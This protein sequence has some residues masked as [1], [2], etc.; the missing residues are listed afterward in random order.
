MNEPAK[1]PLPKPLRVVI[2]AGTAIFLSPLFTLLPF[3]QPL[4]SRIMGGWALVWVA[5]VLGSAFVMLREYFSAPR[6]P[7]G[8]RSAKDSSDDYHE[9]N[10]RRSIDPSK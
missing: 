10:E 3:E 5:I 9:N 1:K 2:L 8:T 6:K 7:G 4:P